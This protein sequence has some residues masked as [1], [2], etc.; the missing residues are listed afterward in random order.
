M[1]TLLFLHCAVNGRGSIPP[2]PL[3][4]RQ[5]IYHEATPPTLCEFGC[6]ECRKTLCHAFVRRPSSFVHLDNMPRLCLD[7]FVAL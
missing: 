6:D 1:G 7:C 5:K 4:L 3:E 2:L